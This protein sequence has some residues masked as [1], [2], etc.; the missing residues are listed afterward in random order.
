MRERMTY[1]DTLHHK[2]VLRKFLAKN[3]YCHWKLTTPRRRHKLSWQKKWGGARLSKLSKFAIRFPKFRV[4]LW[5]LQN[6]KF[7]SQ[8]L[9]IDFLGILYFG[10][11][12]D[13]KPELQM[14]YAGSKLSLVN[15]V[16]A[17]VYISLIVESFS[18][19]SSQN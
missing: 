11:F 14:M 5:I 16:S 15:Q 12:R 2:T 9:S 3:L 17:V 6:R 13:C 1:R 10:P 8:T 18:S 7:W 19:I 4:N